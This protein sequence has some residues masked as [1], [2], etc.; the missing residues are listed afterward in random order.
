MVRWY[1][2]AWRNSTARGSHGARGTRYVRVAC[3]GEHVACP[4]ACATSQHRSMTAGRPDFR[5]AA[6]APGHPRMFQAARAGA[7]MPVPSGPGLKGSQG[8]FVLSTEDY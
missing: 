6:T 2:L 5:V 3:C 1:C 8:H 7:D 4:T